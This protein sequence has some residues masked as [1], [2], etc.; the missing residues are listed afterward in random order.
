VRSTAPS[1]G[2]NQP[3]LHNGHRLPIESRPPLDLSTQLK[4]SRL[5]STADS[6]YTNPTRPSPPLS[7]SAFRGFNV[8]RSFQ[9][10]VEPNLETNVDSSRSWPLDSRCGAGEDI[11]DNANVFELRLVAFSAW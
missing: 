3:V 6:S 2:F 1:L 5:R 8:E 4:E 11:D 9:R 7:I 10:A